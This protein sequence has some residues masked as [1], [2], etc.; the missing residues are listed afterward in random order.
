VRLDNAI[1]RI[2]RDARKRGK[3]TQSELAYRTGLDPM[4]VSRIERGVRMPSITTLFLIARA[5][6]EDAHEIVR[7][8][9]QLNPQVLL[10]EDPRGYHPR[11][12][13]GKRGAR[14]ES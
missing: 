7:Q 14:A 9:E 2:L 13:R 4:T 8:V 3:L 5:L 11:P 1:A 10:Q 6:G 12:V